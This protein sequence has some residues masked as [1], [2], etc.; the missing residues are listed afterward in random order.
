MRGS[1]FNDEQRFN[2]VNEIVN[3]L[4]ANVPKKTAYARAAIHNKCSPQTAYNTFVRYR[5]K[6]KLVMWFE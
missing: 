2:I 6:N 5:K 3:L 4:N 1:K